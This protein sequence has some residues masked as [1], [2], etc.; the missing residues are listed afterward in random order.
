MKPAEPIIVKCEI[1]TYPRPM[2]EGMFD[3]MP[4]VKVVFDNGVEKVLFDFFPDEISFTEDEFIGLTEE[5]AIRL[6]TEKDIKFLQS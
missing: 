4:E 1:G 5:A 2:P 6:R 3:P